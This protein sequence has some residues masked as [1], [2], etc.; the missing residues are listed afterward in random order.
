MSPAVCNSMPV[1]KNQPK[2][3]TDQLLAEIKVDM[4]RQNA[5][6]IP[7]TLRT[8]M[9]G[10]VIIMGDTAKLCKTSLGKKPCVVIQSVDFPNTTQLIGCRFLKGSNELAIEFLKNP[11]KIDK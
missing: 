5:S 6:H 11:L 10:P 9:S 4:V 2:E 1:E 3:K 8:L 7:P